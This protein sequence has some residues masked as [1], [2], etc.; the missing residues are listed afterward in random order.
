MRRVR[1]GRA[2]GARMNGE[3]KLDFLTEVAKDR[4]EPVHGEAREINVA[5]PHKLA[6]RYTGSCFGLPG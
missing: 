1:F 6:V 2:A 5:D 3:R 4:H